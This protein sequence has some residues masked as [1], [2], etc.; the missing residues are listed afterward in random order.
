MLHASRLLIVGNYDN[1]V[2]T[3]PPVFAYPSSNTF[4]PED[5][6]FLL[7]LDVLPTQYHNAPVSVSTVTGLP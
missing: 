5:R 3:D 2:L 4:Y 7:V 6:R 1:S